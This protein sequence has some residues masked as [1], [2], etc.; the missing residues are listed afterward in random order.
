[1]YNNDF[2]FS[3]IKKM[4]TIENSSIEFIRVWQGH[5]IEQRWFS[6]LN[7]NG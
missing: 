3:E 2:D 7:L 5:R 6:A 4:Y 1:L